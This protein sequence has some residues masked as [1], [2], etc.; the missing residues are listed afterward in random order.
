MLLSIVIPAYNEEKRI[1]RTL[2]HYV[3]YFKDQDV[4]FVIVPNGCRDNTVAIVESFIKHAHGKIRMS[5]ITEAIGKGGAV[6]HGFALAAGDYIGFVDADNATE[7]AEYAKVFE[8]LKQG[9]FDGAIASRWK[10][11]SQMI[12]RNLIRK[13]VSF[14][15]IILVKLIFWMPY[16]DTQCG[17][18][19]FKK[20]VVHSILPKLTVSN[21]AFDVD[22]L[23]QAKKRKFKIIEVPTT[24]FNKSNSA[25]L[26]SPFGTV[27]NAC[28]MFFT[29]LKIRF[30]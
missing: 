27:K 19:I 24:W 8:K 18:K 12:G 17:A 20:N 26:G 6:K 16:F 4:E 21:M 3:D 1:L 9:S 29:L 13:I 30:S 15:F 2:E 7:P 23:W 5:I 10:Q 25:T 11:G 22:M 28:K 14:G